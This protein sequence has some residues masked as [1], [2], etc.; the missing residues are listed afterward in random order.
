[1]NNLNEFLN[2]LNEEAGGKSSGNDEKK[3][4]RVVTAQE[5][6]VDQMFWG[7]VPASIKNVY[8]LYRKRLPQEEK[9][10]HTFY[11]FLDD[12]VQYLMSFSMISNANKAGELIANFDMGVKEKES[13]ETEKE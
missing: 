2:T 7:K 1:M 11:E 8:Y 12:V 3:S 9:D 5:A 4:G 13:K 10:A 6:G